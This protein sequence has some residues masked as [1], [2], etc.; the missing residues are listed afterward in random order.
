ME[1]DQT[2]KV[3]DQTLALEMLADNSVHPK[4]LMSLIRVHRMWHT[5]FL[6]VYQAP[7]KSV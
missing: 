7:V 5:V 1:I 6:K 4:I 3:L 2:R